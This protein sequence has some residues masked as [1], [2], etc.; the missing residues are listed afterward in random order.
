MGLGRRFA[1]FR[2][3]LGG[4]ASPP[5]GDGEAA[6][7][8]EAEAAAG[9]PARP[10]LVVGLGNPGAEY[11]GT[12]HNA[13]ARCVERLAARGGARLARDRR[14]WRAAIE[15]EGR[16]LHLASPRGWYNE[17]GPAVAAELRRLRLDRARLLVVYDEIDLPLGRVRMRPRGGHGGNNGMRSILGALGG[18]EFPRVRIGVDRPYDGGAPVRDPDRVADWVLS[19]PGPDEREALDAAIE[20]AA[21]AIEHAVREGVEA[22]MLRLHS[23]P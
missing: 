13:G 4:A 3:R 23:A 8:A 16:A 6:R 21:D 5:R 9:E 17:S 15:V 10:A 14:A 1:A 19:P 12:R 20:A 2:D 18:G 7:G 11:R 22:A